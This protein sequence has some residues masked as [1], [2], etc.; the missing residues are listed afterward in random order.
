MAA[1][2]RDLHWGRGATFPV[3]KGTCSYSRYCHA[4]RRRLLGLK[5]RAGRIAAAQ[6][7]DLVLVRCRSAGTLALAPGEDALV[8]HGGPESVDSVMVDG[9][10]LMR[11]KAPLA[12]DEAA[13]LTEVE[14]V[15]AGLQER[16]AARLA[17]LGRNAPGV[18]LGRYR[19]TDSSYL[20]ALRVPF[21]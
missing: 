20:P 10:W 13:A 14:T 8:Q 15:V 21:P 17:T 12:F 3:D 9:R 6:L 11:G 4:Q 18:R 19:A 7:A 2:Y 5:N 16:T 1:L